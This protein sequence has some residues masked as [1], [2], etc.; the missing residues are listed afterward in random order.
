MGAQN[1]PPSLPGRFNSPVL[2]GQVTVST[3][4][5]AT[6]DVGLCGASG[7]YGTSRRI[8]VTGVVFEDP[9]ADISTVTVTI[10][11]SGAA[12]S[13]AASTTLSGLSAAG[14]TYQ[15]VSPKAGAAILQATDLRVTIGTGVAS[16]TCKV[17][18]LGYL[19]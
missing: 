11:T 9:S 16:Q 10:G 8:V 13:I 7:L 15:V 2:L 5:A 18:V 3:T 17:S 6:T 14:A 12:T 19:E 1:N 4:A